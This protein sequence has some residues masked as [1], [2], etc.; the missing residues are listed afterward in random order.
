MNLSPSE[1]SDGSVDTAA[2][3]VKRVTKMMRKQARPLKE[4]TA[5]MMVNQEKLFKQTVEFFDA[6]D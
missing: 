2:K 3:T 4:I 1:H 5:W 6:A